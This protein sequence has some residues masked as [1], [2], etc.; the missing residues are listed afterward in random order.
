MAGNTAVDAVRSALRLGAKDAFIVYRRS[1]AQMP[2]SSEELEAAEDEGIKFHYLLA[3][4][5][6]IGKDGKVTELLCN[7]MKL[8]QPDASGRRRPIPIEGATTSF[9]VDVVIPALGQGV[10]YSIFQSAA[11][12]SRPEMGFDRR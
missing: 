3:P 8:G 10:D 12:R 2:V 7:Q 6:I 5:E 4:A 11:E 1:E 9:N